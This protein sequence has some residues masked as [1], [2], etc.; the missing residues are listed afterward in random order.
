MNELQEAVPWSKRR[1]FWTV[2]GILAV[3]VA[4]IWS[5]SEPQHSVASRPFSVSA[6]RLLNKQI[7][8][9]TEWFELNDP[10]LF[11]LT[12]PK[13]FSGTAW[14]KMEPF[15]YRLTNKIEPNYWLAGDSIPLAKSASGLIEIGRANK[16]L[17]AEKPSPAVWAVQVPA[18]PSVVRPSL[19]L[20][21]D[22]S[23]RFLVSTNPL[24][25]ADADAVLANC[26]IS[27]TVNGGGDVISHVPVSS[28]GSPPIDVKAMRFAKAA[29]FAPLEDAGGLTIGNFVFQWTAV[30]LTETNS[31]ALKQ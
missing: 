9:A 7:E 17:G 30:T 5:F 19:R 1:W 6:V 15:P 22:L 25:E 10:A 20:E 24:P 29:R 18:K 26:V 28:S 4:F 3:H 23:A 13:G 27:V 12:S 21:G 11:A 31:D 2:L 8:P 16:L 14:L